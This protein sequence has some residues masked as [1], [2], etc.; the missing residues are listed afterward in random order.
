M[1]MFLTASNWIGIL[2]GGY[3]CYKL[4]RVALKKENK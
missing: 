2:C 3:V 4:A 1:A